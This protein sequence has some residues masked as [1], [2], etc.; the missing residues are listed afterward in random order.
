MSTTDHN[1]ILGVIHL[2]YGAFNV[3]VMTLLSIFM[4]G[5]LGFAAARTSGSEAAGMGL[6]ALIMVF[7]IGLNLLFTVPEFVTGYAL[8][9]RKKWAKIAG[10][11]SAILE[12]L[13]F[14]F[15]TA[16]CVYTLWFLF[17]EH[18]RVIYDQPRGALPP[19]PVQ[20]AGA[21]VGRQAE[22]VPPAGPPDWR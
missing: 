12:S 7:V 17:S 2:A 14:P 19:P 21:T 3:L 10:V 8:L 11:I 20:W 16:L 1:K 6:F 9:K 5:V 18:G 15:G 13:S 4:F 22:Y